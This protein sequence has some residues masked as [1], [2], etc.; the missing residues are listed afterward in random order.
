MEGHRKVRDLLRETRVSASARASFPI[1]ADEN[2]E[3]LWVPGAA[4]SSAY[5]VT[6]STH[7]V[8]VFWMNDSDKLQQALRGVTVEE[9][10]Q[11]E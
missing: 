9:Q 3:V 7:N 2:G 4:R 11:E 1:V 8:W 6:P 10:D 5:P